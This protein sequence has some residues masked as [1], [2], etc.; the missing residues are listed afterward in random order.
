MTYPTHSPGPR[1]LAAVRPSSLAAIGQRQLADGRTVPPQRTFK[2]EANAI[3]AEI[4]ALLSARRLRTRRTAERHDEPLRTVLAKVVAGRRPGEGA[5]AVPEVW[6]PALMMLTT[7]PEAAVRGLCEYDIE[8]GI[9]VLEIA[10]EYRIV[11]APVRPRRL[12]TRARRTFAALP[13]DVL[14]LPP[15]TDPTIAAPLMADERWQARVLTAAECAVLLE[16]NH[17]CPICGV[18]ATGGSHRNH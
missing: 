3:R 4:A 7:T 9:P 1:T 18:T 6:T 12:T 14:L 5:E 17:D 2:E 10:D 16:P 15:D 8:V 13:T 11:S